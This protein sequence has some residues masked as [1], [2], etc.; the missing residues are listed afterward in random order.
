MRRLLLASGNRDKLSELTALL[1]DVP[2]QLLTPVDVGLDDLDVLED[3]AD[4]AANAAL[5]AAAFSQAS[6]LPCLADD[7]GLEV[8]ALGGAPGVHSARL[9]PG[10][11]AQR[12]A[13]LLELLAGHPQPWTARFVSTVC[14]ALP[15]DPQ[16][17]QHFA[18]GECRGEIVAQERG[19]GG[20]G[21]DPIFVVAGTGRTMAEFSFREK[22]KLSHRADAVTKIKPQLRAAFGLDGT[23]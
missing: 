6:G 2:V 8:A 15:G 7:S 9:S 12:R 10:D 22:N 18:Q 23:L 20:F 4:Y 3:G 11:D 14:L 1:A 5:K 19:V 21:Y 16:P 17:Q 13:R